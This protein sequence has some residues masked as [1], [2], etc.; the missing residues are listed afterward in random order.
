MQFYRCQRLANYG[1]DQQSDAAA[2]ERGDELRPAEGGG[3]GFQH[4]L[5][6]RAGRQQRRCHH[7]AD[8]LYHDEV[9]HG[10]LPQSGNEPR[11]DLLTDL[12]AV[13]TGDQPQQDHKHG[14]AD[15]DGGKN[16]DLRR[17]AQQVGEHRGEHGHDDAAAHSGGQ[18][19]NGQHG[20]DAGAGDKL[21]KALGQRL[22]SD[23]KCQHNGGF[24]DPT[25]FF[26]HSRYLF[27]NYSLEIT[28]E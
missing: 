9:Q 24:G 26:V 23:E 22:Q 13:R 12:P 28:P 21:A 20:V 19:G 11:G 10:K 25:Y 14:V 1:N 6:Q 15:H 3:E 17:D 2:N 27:P 8:D 16:K 4:R 7:A 5:L 18:N